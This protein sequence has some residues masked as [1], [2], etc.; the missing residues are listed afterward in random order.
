MHVLEKHWVKVKRRGRQL[1]NR[2]LGELHSDKE[3]IF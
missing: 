2:L 1:C 3:L